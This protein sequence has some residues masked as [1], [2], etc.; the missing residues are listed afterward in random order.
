MEGLA[1]SAGAACHGNSVELS[2]TLRALAVPIEWARGTIRL[3]TGKYTSEGEV[4][5]AVEIIA[6]AVKRLRAGGMG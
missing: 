6:G 4:D 1:A 2:R 3:S 5:R